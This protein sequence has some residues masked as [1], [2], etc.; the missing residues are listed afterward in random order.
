MAYPSNVIQRPPV[1]RRGCAAGCI[2]LVAALLA[3]TVITFLIVLPNLTS[4]LPAVGAQIAGLEPAGNTAEQF[5]Q[6]APM[7]AVELQNAQPASNVSVTASQIGSLNLD[8]NAFTVG[9]TSAGETVS[10]A[11]YSESQL[12]ELCRARSEICGSGNGQIR[13]AQIDLRPGGAIVRGEVFFPQINLWQNIGVVLKTGGTTPRL[14]LTG[15]DLNGNFFSL[16]EGQLGDTARQIESAA[17]D[18]LQQ[19]V[20]TIDGQTLQVSELYADDQQVM[21]VFR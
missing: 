15:V 3:F 19:A 18:A 16:P 21:V 17:N 14:E 12:N 13:N 4:I 6:S 2:L 9:Q 7:P 10:T 1:R 11:T 8:A 20:A 5:Q